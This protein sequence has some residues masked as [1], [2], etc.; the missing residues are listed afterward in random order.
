M[1]DIDKN[2]ENIADIMKVIE[3]YY[4]QFSINGKFGNPSHFDTYIR[5]NYPNFDTLSKNKTIKRMI[6]FVNNGG[7][8][9]P[10]NFKDIVDSNLI[11]RSSTYDMTIFSAGGVCKTSLIENFVFNEV[12]T[13]S[14][15]PVIGY[16]LIFFVHIVYLNIIF[17]IF[18]Y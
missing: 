4:F 11:P 8:Y 18:N 16:F 5:T 6:K 9:F 14:Y 17:L 7:V 3:D 1:I 2:E 10:S 15:S 13:N 12:R